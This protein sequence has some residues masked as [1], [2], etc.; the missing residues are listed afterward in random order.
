MS[1]NRITQ[2]MLNRSL[3][4]DLNG[5]SGRLSH[6]QRKL[7]SG[8]EINRPSDDPFA[9]SRAIQLRDE[10][11]GVQQ[12]KRNVSEALAWN[13]VTETAL[14]G[15][16]DAI[17]TARERVIQAANGALDGVSREGIATEI[18]QLIETVK[19]HMNATYGD[20]YVFSGTATDTAPYSMGA[21]DTYAGDHATIARE[22]GPGVSVQVNVFGDAILGNG[23]AAA[24]NKL[25]NVLR[26][27][28][29]HLRGNSEAD[30]NALRGID[31]QRLDANFDELSR[32]RAQVGAVTNRL[33]SAEGSLG[34]LEEN[35]MSLLS[36][37]EDADMAKTL[38]DFST[39]QN[40][41]QSALKAGAQ[42]IHNSLLDF[43]G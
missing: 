41:Y 8:R 7:S 30:V 4:T 2:S 5:A 11:E 34:E 24:D 1:G 23:Q 33:E 17:Q 9:A 40:V 38:V 20:R 37:T 29:Q 22:I 42:V 31:L 18:D 39:Q 10:L 13:N 27:I 19:Q 16:G 25:L 36:D 28:S 6:T 43:L 3:L 15:V 32:V 35:T 14:S 21:V 12:F 26:D